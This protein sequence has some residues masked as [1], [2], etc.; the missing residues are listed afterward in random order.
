MSFQGSKCVEFAV[1]PGLPAASPSTLPSSRPCAGRSSTG[2][3]MTRAFSSLQN[4]GLGEPPAEHHRPAGGHQP[5]S[6]ED[7]TIWIAYNG[8]VYNFPDVSE[9]LIGR[10]HTF[11][12]RSERKRSSTPTRNGARSSSRNSGACSP[13]PS[14]T[15]KRSRLLLVRDRVGVKPLYY[16][17]LRT[18]RWSSGPS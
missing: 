14:G 8:E 9:K 1:S 6:N 16:T 2:A 3:R 11:N 4:V 7:G 12:T 15:K 17:L 13:L 10:G 18:G 5:L